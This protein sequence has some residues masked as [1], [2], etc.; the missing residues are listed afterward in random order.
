MTHRPTGKVF[1]DKYGKIAS[2][3]VTKEAIDEAIEYGKVWTTD[4]YSTGIADNG[5]INIH[6]DSKSDVF[7]LG[8]KIV[9]GGD[10]IVSLIESPTIDSTGTELD[11]YNLNRIDATSAGIT[12]YS[13]S[14]FS[15]G[16]TITEQYIP[17]GEKTF[18]R[19]VL[20]ALSRIIPKKD[21]DYIIQVTNK[22]GGSTFLGISIQYEVE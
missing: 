15:S 21:S 18:S 3:N 14:S 9:S 2:R 8:Y 17:G 16:T 1:H 4:Y 11:V 20:T 12:A 19:G 6:I 22:S 7:A 10:C 13:D 5:T